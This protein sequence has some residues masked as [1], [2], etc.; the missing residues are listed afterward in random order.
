[1]VSIEILVT[2]VTGDWTTLVDL[3]C[4]HYDIVYVCLV[5]VL[6]IVRSFLL[7]Q[8][9]MWIDMIILVMICILGED[10]MLVTHLRQMLVEL[11][12]SW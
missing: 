6:A 5:A 11:A 3:R 1:M 4:M 2:V 9:K 8:V 7:F 12:D 10:K